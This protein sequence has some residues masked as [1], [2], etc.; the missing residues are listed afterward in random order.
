MNQLGGYQKI[1]SMNASVLI[2]CVKQ[3]Q[4]IVYKIDKIILQQSVMQKCYLLLLMR[5]IGNKN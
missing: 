5:K 3:S 2:N 4:C 1:N